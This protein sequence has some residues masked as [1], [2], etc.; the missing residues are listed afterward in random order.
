MWK[1]DSPP[2]EKENGKK[3]TGERDCWVRRKWQAGKGAISLR[4]KGR[5][6]MHEADICR[7]LQIDKRAGA[8]QLQGGDCGQ[9]RKG[10]RS[11]RYGEGIVGPRRAPTLQGPWFVPWVKW[12]VTTGSGK[13]GMTGFP[14]QKAHYDTWGPSKAT[15]VRSVKAVVFP[16]VMYGC[17]SWAIKKAE[18]QRIDAFEL[19]C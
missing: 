19:W 7:C 18:G 3:D 15:V 2:W 9:R 8:K 11:G 16:V 6:G 5:Q 17:E 4:F 12:R 10:S 13:N 1:G 14:F